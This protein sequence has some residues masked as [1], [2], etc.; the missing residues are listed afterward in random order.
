MIILFRDLVNVYLAR[1]R[2]AFT[3]R[4]YRWKRSK[5]LLV[6]FCFRFVSKVLKQELLECS[7]L[8]FLIFFH[9]EIVFFFIICFLDFFG[10]SSNYGIVIF[11]FSQNSIQL[12]ISS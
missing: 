5:T 11:S 6:E 7:F 1:I 12:A 3:G 2:L 10:I 4:L 8:F 9:L